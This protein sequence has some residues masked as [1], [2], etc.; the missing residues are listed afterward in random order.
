MTKLFVTAEPLNGIFRLGRDY[1]KR[2]VKVMRLKPGDTLLV[3]TSKNKYECRLLEILPDEIDL[4]IVRELPVLQEPALH[5]ILGQAIP[6]GDRFEW[7]IQKATELG[8]AEIYPLITERTIVKPDNPGAKMQRWN[9]IA[10]HAAGQSENQFPSLIHVPQHLPSFLNEPINSKLKLL[11]HERKEAAS[12]REILARNSNAHRITFVVGPEGGWTESETE[13]MLSKGYEL[14]HLGPRI[15]RAETSG[16]VM[17]T[18]LQY[19]LG[20]FHSAQ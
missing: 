4:Q 19:E 18:L 7:L 5:L 20:D 15:L 14:V 3:I 12:L 1:K 11:L 9:E 6:K 2:L 8:V 17:A 13:Q 10:A 16:L